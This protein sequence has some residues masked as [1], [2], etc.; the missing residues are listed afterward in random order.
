MKK[1][2]CLVL[3]FILSLFIITGCGS[4][5]TYKI[6]D[7]VST[8]IANFKLVAGEFAYAL[9]NTSG[10]DFA[11]PKEYDAKDDS[12]NPYVAAK[13]HTL[14]AFTFY[15]ENLDRSSLDMGGSFNSVFAKV[16]YDKKEYGDTNEQVVEF[17][18]ESEDYLNW[19]SYSSD[20]I[21]LS[22][23][24]KLYYRAYMDIPVDVSS[25]DDT[26]EITI[27]LPNSGGKTEEFTYVIS[28]DD[29]NNFK[30]VELEE[31]VAIKNLSKG[32]VQEYFNSRLSDYTA[33]N[34]TDIK[35][36]IEGKKFNVTTLGTGTWEGTFKFETSGKIYEG[37]NKYV[38]GYT[39]KRTWVVTGDDLI[40]SWV[41]G[42]GET[43][44]ETY[45]VKKVKDGTY[46]LVSSD[47]VAGIL[48]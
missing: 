8:D 42:R 45:S 18:A 38:S 20:N 28:E 33:V 25:L 10:S 1:K 41:N 24:D 11:I 17:K 13:G 29:R 43:K 23:G 37:G 5:E 7:A 6:G 4:S 32:V 26:V 36:A 34:G 47:K 21:L 46:L 35:T 9:E 27:Y 31:D 48:Y 22:A 12:N 3:V 16:K 15:I 39:N 40:L 44:S 14:V 19:K 2:I 30:G